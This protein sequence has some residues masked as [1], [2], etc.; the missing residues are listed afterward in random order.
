MTA[1]GVPAERS[2]VLPNGI[3]VTVPLA[4]TGAERARLREEMAAG[5]GD[6]LLLNAGRLDPQKGQDLL[7]A[8]LDGVPSPVH[9][10]L[11]GDAVAAR[12]TADH[13]TLLHR[14]VQR[15]GLERR[16]SFLG[17]RDD[18]PR[19]LAAADGYVP[20]ARWGGPRAAA[21]GPGGHG[22]RLPHRLH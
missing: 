8:A 20:T 16:V 15:L 9:V 22:R 1:F 4:L 6:L 19:L 5:E 14:Q 2:V 7:L 13:A 21:L 10:A 11:V 3:S 17:W 18:V 12:R